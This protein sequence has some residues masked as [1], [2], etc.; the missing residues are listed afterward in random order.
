MTKFLQ[1]DQSG[2]GGGG[3]GGY[4]VFVYTLYA[5]SIWAVIT[6]YIVGQT[7]TKIKDNGSNDNL[8]TQSNISISYVNGD[9]YFR[10]D[11]AGAR[12]QFLR[13]AK[14]AGAEL[15]FLPVI[16]SL[17]I[18]VAVIRGRQTRKV[19]LHTSGIHGESS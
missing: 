16:G 15:S 19:L 12:E 10:E 13:S 6:A 9:C 7:S 2:G 11:H 4:T 17:G 8:C 3:G 14:L 1:Q 5:V 18:D